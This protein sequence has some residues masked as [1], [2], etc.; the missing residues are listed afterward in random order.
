MNVCKNR[1]LG[2]K[3]SKKK[4]IIKMRGNTSHSKVHAN[5]K[6]LVVFD[7]AKEKKQVRVTGSMAHNI[8]LLWQIVLFRAKPSS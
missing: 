4:I 7:Q 1:E 2:R 6:A 5:K 3:N 8:H